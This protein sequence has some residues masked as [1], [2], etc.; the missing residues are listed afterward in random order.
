MR[1]CAAYLA[2]LTIV[3][4]TTALIACS[5]P[6]FRYA[7]EQW[8]P[9]S[10]EVSVYYR[11]ELS[12]AHTAL[13][14]QLQPA[15]LDAEYTA[16]VRVRTVDVDSPDNAEEAKA[17][18]ESVTDEVAWMVARTPAK[19][20]APTEVASAVF[21]EQNL[22]RLLDSPKRAE[23]TKRL[24][25]GDSVVWMLLESGVK[26]VDDAAEK[27]L[28]DELQRLQGVLKL[29][30]IDE[31]DI[32]DGFLSVDPDELKIR[33]SVIRLA[34]DDPQEQAFLQMLLSTEPDLKDAEF[35]SQT[36]ALP[37]FGRGRSLYALIGKG[38]NAETIEDACRFLT[39]ACQCTV[40]A[41]NPGVDLL[42]TVDWDSLVGAAPDSLQLESESTTGPAEL[43]AIPPGNSGKTMHVDPAVMQT[44]TNQ[45]TGWLYGFGGFAV[46]VAGVSLVFGSQ[47]RE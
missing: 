33:F 37:V 29:P 46:L 2:A 10:F 36:M 6:V 40:K 5:V 9:D 3:L 11:G 30:D 25:K 12:E 28:S 23:L 16:N 13:I 38:I 4:S 47:R 27:T 31:K 14:Q 22:K 15:S 41:Q 20:G 39:G 43:V 45:D 26:E 35:V 18:S 44:A 34:R 24:L 19:H 7:L 1:R 42:T 21:N 17:W 32:Q 8:N